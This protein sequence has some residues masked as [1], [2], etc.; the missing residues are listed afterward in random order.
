[1]KQFLQKLKQSLKTF[2]YKFD[3]FTD[4][5]PEI[6]RVA[7]MRFGQERGSEAAASL[8]YYAFFSIFPMLLVFIVIG[9]YFLDRNVVQQ[10]I[11]NL[12]QGVLPGAKDLVIGN[13]DQVLQLRG[14]VTF[15]ALIT[16]IWSATSVFNILAKN[17]NR[18]FP[19]AVVPDFLKGRWMGFLMLLAMGLLGILAFAVTT[20]VGLIPA[21]QI[22]FNDKSLHETLLWQIGSFLVPIG[23]NTLAFWAM[24]YW[25][26]SV[27]VSRKASLIGALVTGV[28]WEILNN[29]FTWYLSS[30]LSQ[31]R[32]VYGSLW[33]VV[34]LLFWI[35]L[36]SSLALLGAHLTAS[37][38]SAIHRKL[39]EQHT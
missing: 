21:I 31:Y 19:K 7:F 20:G 24:Y 36:T 30:G 2:Y 26:P 13:I 37:I 33:T 29:V 39:N 10:Q 9:S 4:G 27:D 15:L 12:L 1:M 25:V 32:L 17:I 14:A 5:V 6:I 23:F 34:A 22:P 8:A 28:T 35:Y 3:E 11:L 38:Q 16:L 18:A